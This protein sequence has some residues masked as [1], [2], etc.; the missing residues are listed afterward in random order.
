MRQVGAERFYSKDSYIKERGGKTPEDDGVKSESVL[1]PDGTTKDMYKAWN[2]MVL[3]LSFTFPILLVGLIGEKE[4]YY[5]FLFFPKC[6]MFRE[7]VSRSDADLNQVF[8]LRLI[9]HVP[10]WPSPAQYV[11]SH[12]IKSIVISNS[13]TVS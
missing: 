10:T 1:L 13:V 7:N 12:D 4:I 3:G 5:L 11:T 8:P 2:G 9:G 6:K